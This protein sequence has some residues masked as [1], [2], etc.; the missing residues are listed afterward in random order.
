MTIQNIEDI[1]N[2]LRDLPG[3]TEIVEFKEARNGYDF[4]KLGKYFSALCNEVNL[5]GKSHAWLVFGIE[6]EHHNI[7]GSQFRSK[8]KDLDSLKAEIADKT[9]NRI[10]FIEIHEL[11]PPEGRVVLFQIPAAPRGIPVT[12]EGHYYGRDGEELVPLNLEE[13]E[14]IRAQVITEDWSAAIVPN[15]T[16]EDLDGEAIEKARENFKSKFPDYA[17]D[18]DSWDTLTF[19]NKAKITCKG[20]ITRTAIILLGKDESEQLISPA[21]AKIRWLLKDAGGNDRDY[22]IVGCPMLLS[23]DKVYAKIRNL[24]YRYLKDGTLFPDELD[25]YEPFTIREALNNCI[26]HQDYTKNGRINVVEMDDQLLFTNLGSFIPG[27]VEKVVRENAPEEYYRNRFLATA[28]FNLKMVDT[29][30]GGIRKMFNFQRERFFPMPDYV[31][32]PERVKM[33]ITGKV[34]DVEYARLLARNRDLTLEEIIMLDKVQKKQPLTDFEEKHLKSKK[35]IEG[36]KPNF[37]IGIRIAQRIGQKAAYSKNKAFDKQYYLDLI[38]KSVTEHGSLNR[39]DIDELLWKKLPDW[40][41]EKQR[42]IKISNLI[43]ELRRKARI[44]NVGSDRAPKWV[45]LTN[46]D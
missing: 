6:N 14:R 43:S 32:T 24:K 42:G 22:L 35:L 29:V 17:A 25:Q 10:T 19:L 41:D 2:D 5:M 40:M 28:M 34:L 33:T 4:T 21:V 16:L 37:F 9:T 45:F 3:E 18:A 38:L 23:V 1:L 7:V 27:S 46:Q 26:A 8:R 13:I 15:A 36:H 30:G 39:H 44:R 12:F 20:Q 11:Y 31:L